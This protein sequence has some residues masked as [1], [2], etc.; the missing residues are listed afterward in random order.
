MEITKALGKLGSARDSRRGFTRAS[1]DGPTASAG[2]GG[3][4]GGGRTTGGATGGT[5]PAAAG[6]LPSPVRPTAREMPRRGMRQ[7]GR[8]ETKAE[9]EA[10]REGLLR[11]EPTGAAGRGP[12]ATGAP[13]LM[14][15]V[16]PGATA[17]ASCDAMSKPHPTLPAPTLSTSHLS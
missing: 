12:H 2:G 10:A 13:A 11:G 17:C 8:P 15:R 7:R 9:I 6:A 3:G 4:G 16:P 5:T 1:A 14:V